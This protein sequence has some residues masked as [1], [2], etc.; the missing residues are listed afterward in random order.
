MGLKRSFLDTDHGQL[1]YRTAGSGEA[2]LLLHMSPRSSD[3]FLELMPLLA[4][5]YQVIAMD[6]MGFGDSDTPP[7]SYTMAD[8]AGDAIALLNSLNIQTASI[9][10]HTFGAFVAGEIAAAYPDRVNKLIL[11]NI[12]GL[13]TAATAKVNKK[14]ATGFLLKDDGSHLIDRWAARLQYIG[15]PA[16]NHRWVLD[17]LKAFGRTAYAA[18]AATEYWPTAAQRFQHIACPTLLLWG[19]QEVNE[20]ERQG[21]AQAKNRFWVTQA[22]ANHQVI[23]LDHGTICMMNQIPTEI[24]QL[25]TTFLTKSNT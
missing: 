14:Y 7:K 22:I 8:Y 12:L 2:V 24:S 15:S 6:M 4:T 16:L 11:C 10:G 25:V 17:D 19:L 9:L 23:E 18:R 3:E 1:L 13:D 5:E 20:F 21:L